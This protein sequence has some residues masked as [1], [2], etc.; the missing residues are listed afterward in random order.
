[1]E[2]TTK[3]S[4]N[5]NYQTDCA[6]KNFPSFALGSVTRCEAV[7][8]ASPK[9]SVYLLEITLA[10]NAPL[11]RAGQFYMLRA[12]KSGTLLARPISVFHVAQSESKASV[13]FLI[14]VK[15]Q[16]T[17]ELCALRAQDKVQMLGPLGNGFEIFANSNA[18]N[19]NAPQTK[20]ALEKA[21]R[22]CLVGGGIGVAPVAGFAETL[23]PESYDFLP[24]SKV[25]A[26]V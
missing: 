23:I 3:N 25:A 7:E 13:Q 17:R 9:G 20:T 22:V 26:M 14:L 21:A 2:K 24:A 11:P 16:G 5:N 6:R 10:E 18:P 1:M 15:G 19:S 4:I 8:N 12:E